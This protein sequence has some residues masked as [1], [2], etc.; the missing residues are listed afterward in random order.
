[1]ITGN[2]T[3][4]WVFL[5]RWLFLFWIPVHPSVHNTWLLMNAKRSCS[6]IDVSV[7]H[8]IC[9]SFQLQVYQ[10]A[11]VI[12]K[13]ANSPRPGNWIL[14]RS[15]DGVEYKPW[16]YYAISDS[17]CW[18]AYGIEPTIG[19]PKFERDDDV[20]CYSQYSRLDP[21]QGGEVSQKDARRTEL[22]VITLSFC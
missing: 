13:A 10:V 7:Q 16:Q 21:L 17:E 14:E 2:C 8:K 1:M 19:I 22:S 11:Y 15:L 9:A 18:N 5:F 12:V 6:L 3:C 20:L 4:S